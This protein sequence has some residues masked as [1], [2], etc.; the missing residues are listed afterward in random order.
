[1]FNLPGKSHITP[2][3]A[4][5]YMGIPNIFMMH[6]RGTPKP[7]LHQVALPF[8]AL[9][10]VIWGIVGDSG[11][12]SA[13][14]REMVLE[15]A[16]SNPKIS[17]V[18]MDDFFSDKKVG[19][20]ALTLEEVRGLRARLKV[21]RK[22]LDLWV[23]L[24]EHQL[25]YPDLAEYV[26]LCDGIVYATWNVGKLEQLHSR[27]EKA[28]ALVPGTRMIQGCYFWDFQNEK[29]LAISAMKQQCEMGL[30]WLRKGEIE[31]LAFCGSWCCDRGLEAVSWTRQWIQQVGN[32]SVPAL[33]RA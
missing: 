4:A 25:E 26:K 15:E 32:Q 20:A 27:F 6:V 28:R 11:T 18:V 21:A 7:P 17:G 1:M 33:K 31:G 14:E 30:D 3:E 29:P 10:E 13:S 24:Y 5:F 23:V 2:V 12:T 22:R 9:R 19:T 8:E 16:L